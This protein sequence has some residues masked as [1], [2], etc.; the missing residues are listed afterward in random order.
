[1]QCV[2]DLVSGAETSSVGGI[3]NAICH[4]LLFLRRSICIIIP[5]IDTSVK[6]GSCEKVVRGEDLEVEEK[7]YNVGI[8]GSV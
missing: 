5:W 2:N 6:K 4:S 1:M 3:V 7:E 8:G